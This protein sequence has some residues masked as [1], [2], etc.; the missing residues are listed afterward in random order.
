MS[1]LV[2]RRAPKDELSPSRRGRI[3]WA[4]STLKQQ[5]FHADPALP[6]ARTHA[7]RTH[8]L[9]TTA[10]VRSTHSARASPR[11][12]QVVKA[13]AIAE[14][15]ADNRYVE[16]KDDAFFAHFDETALTADDLALF[17]DYLVSIP[18]DRNDAPENAPLMEML[19]S[20]LPVKVLVETSDLYEEAVIGAGHFAFGV[21][22]VRLANTATG[23]G[24][25]YVVQTTAANLPALR[26]RMKQGFA[27]RGAAL[28]SV[29]TGAPA[30]AGDMPPYLTAAA[31]ME[32]R[33]FPAFAYDPYAGDNQAARFILADNRQADADWPQMALEYAD[34]EGQRVAEATSFG[35]VD[36]VLCDRRYARHFARVPR[37]RWNTGMVPGRGLARARCQVAATASCRT[38]SRSTRTTSC[39][40]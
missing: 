26:E 30:P 19:S 15:E 40:A 33:A 11:S 38:C 1:K 7:R 39:I 18:P 12:P 10:P 9:S 29:Y 22:S 37:E 34:T 35:Y 20:G 14:L 16:A 13:L 27:H 17:P 36:F 8:S 32:S 3:E 28:F 2:S 4:L 21:R 6:G 24:G 25:V 23:L 31:A 5:P